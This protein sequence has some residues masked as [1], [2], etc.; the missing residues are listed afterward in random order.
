MDFVDGRVKILVELKGT[1]TAAPLAEVLKKYIAKKNW[2]SQ[3]F[4]VASFNHNELLKFKRLRPQ[5]KAGLIFRNIPKEN[6]DVEEK[7]KQVD[8]VVIPYKFVTAEFV[9]R[10]HKKGLYVGVYTVNTK[11]EYD[12]ARRLNIDIVAT[13]Y[14]DKI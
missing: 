2:N 4:L 7:I 8:Y 6:K 5:I 9:D 1:D 12:C 13:D 11:V 10:M 14:P 3:D